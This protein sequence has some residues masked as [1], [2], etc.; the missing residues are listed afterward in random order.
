M[1]SKYA[2]TSNMQY[3]KNIYAICCRTWTLVKQDGAFD[4]LIRILL[5]ILVNTGCSV[6]L[7]LD[8]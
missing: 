8:Y 5:F 4:A 7:S 3:N 2:K 6:V 1:P